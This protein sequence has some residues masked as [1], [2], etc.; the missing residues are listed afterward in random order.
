[1]KFAMLINNFNHFGDFKQLSQLVDLVILIISNNYF[2]QS[3]W[4]KRL[5]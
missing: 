5:V 3:F 4:H 2:S 1:M